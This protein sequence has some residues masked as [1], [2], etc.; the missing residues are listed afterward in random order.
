MLFDP[1]LHRSLF[2]VLCGAA[3]PG[4]GAH[5]GLP[6][7][8]R[9]GDGVV[10]IRIQGFLDEL[11]VCTTSKRL[12]HGCRLF[13]GFAP[14]YG[15]SEFLL[16][17]CQNRKTIRVDCFERGPLIGLSKDARTIGKAAAAE[18]V[19]RM[20]IDTIPAYGLPDPLF[21]PAMNWPS[22]EMV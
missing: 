16:V 3:A 5:R 17:S 6:R 7:A 10:P 21:P 13:D 1:T 11:S 19:S 12:P 20:G 8:L 15:D 9:Q 2:V 14:A 4:K 22:Y 18:P